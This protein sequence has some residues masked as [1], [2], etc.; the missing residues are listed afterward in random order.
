MNVETAMSPADYRY[1][2]PALFPDGM[3]LFSNSSPLPGT[4]NG[5]ASALFAVPSGNPITA[6]GLPGGLRAGMPAFSPDG[7][8]VAFNY[9]S[10]DQ[11]TLASMDFAKPGTFSN[12]MTLNTPA[13]GKNGW[14]S[15][16]P[17]NDAV[18]YQLETASNGEFFATRES[19][20]GCND[21]SHGELWWVDLAT[22]TAHRL[23]KA[24][25]QGYVPQGP[26]GHTVDATLNFEPT[27][28]PVPSGGYAWV[29]ITSRRMYGNVASINGFWSDPRDHDISQT[30]TT[31]KL[32]VAAIDLNGKAGTD[33]SHPAF[34]LPAQELLAGNSRGFWVVDPCK[35]T[36]ISCE[37]GDECCGGYCQPSD[38]GL[39]CSPN[40]PPCAMEFDKCATDGDC[41]TGLICINGRCA[42]PGPT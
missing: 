21:G 6:S 28:N 42:L 34:Y 35:P 19:C 29:V 26:N 15:F 40:K 33:P 10:S 32:W 38:G 23:D 4:G 7:K 37:S 14:P 3:F 9:Y 8:H 24:N 27:V 41:C 20:G 31:K 18:V 11:K 2:F 12:L 39:V 30:A 16:L 13:S 36:G 22:K 1:A 25:G 17:T 5:A